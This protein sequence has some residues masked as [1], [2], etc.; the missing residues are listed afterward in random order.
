MHPFRL[1]CLLMIAMLVLVAGCRNGDDEPDDASS[2]GA[3]PTVLTAESVLAAAGDRWSS[4]DSAHFKL[5]VDGDA[6]IDT[7]ESIKLLGAEGD[8]ERPNAVK[9]DAKV[10][11]Q[12]TQANVSLIAIG[13]E[14]WMTNFISGNWE[15]APADFSYNPSILFDDEDGIQPILAGLESPELLEAESV[16]GRDARKV[17]GTVSEDTVDRITSGSI[18]G[19]A[20]DVTLWVDS[21]TND[22][23]R[24]SLKEPEGVREK[25]VEW[26]LDLSKQGEAVDIQPPPAS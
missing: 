24:V 7:A 11:I 21:E 23:I 18:Q 5:A 2:A 12:I 10:D 13:D 15:P 22:L 14:A 3:S 25:P 19:D 1:L 9:A 26:T 16:D 20:I 17:T 4:T 8:I 6:Y